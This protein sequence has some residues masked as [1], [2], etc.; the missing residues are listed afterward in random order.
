MVLFGPCDSEVYFR[1]TANVDKCKR[2]VCLDHINISLD[3]KQFNYDIYHLSC[4]SI[5]YFHILQF[6]FRSLIQKW[7]TLSYYRTMFIGCRSVDLHSRYSLMEIRLMTASWPWKRLR[8]KGVNMT[9]HCSR[10]ALS[11][12]KRVFFANPIFAINCLYTLCERVN[13]HTI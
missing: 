2:H 6:V 11:V 9:S 3:S 10:R 7:H 5:G 4:V 12:P 13:I 8:T 1:D